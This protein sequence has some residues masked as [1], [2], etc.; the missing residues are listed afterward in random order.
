MTLV[1][2][3]PHQHF[4]PTQPAGHPEHAGLEP[5]VP[6]LR[7]VDLARIQ[8][9]YL[10]ATAPGTRRTY[11]AYWNVFDRWC[12][13]HGHVSLPAHPATVCAYLTEQADAGKSHHTLNVTC[14]AINRRHLDHGLPS[15]TNM[16]V[17]RRVRR[18]LRRIHGTKIRRPARPLDVA[19]LRRIL[20]AI[21][22]TTPIGLRD[23][24]VI[25]VGFASALRV[26]ELAAL[27]ITDLEPQAAGMLVHIR[28]SKTDPD[29]VGQVVGIA[30]GD[31]AVTDPISALHAW[32]DW[33]GS[34][35]GPLFTSMRG[36]NRSARV[37]IAP[38]SSTAISDIV[39]ERAK[40][41]GLPA[42]RITGHSL[43]AGHATTAAVAGV[44]VE[45]IAA[46]T[47]HRQINILIQHYIRPA[48]TLQ[49][50]SSQHLGL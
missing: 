49:H 10:A 36:V 48:Q 46:Q 3:R 24:A 19:D 43:R 20:A 34:E 39:H 28:S 18:G 35:P 9:A 37:R 26:G 13:E 17:V 50:S 5:E 7:E 15:P 22:R 14:S 23:A 41:A 42:E 45:K 47:R 40:A 30:A 21:D 6:Q 29:G 12:C 2:L 16:D 8:E 27:T 33:R 11:A 1:P 32:L 38:I 44:P 31:D 25:L 4:Q